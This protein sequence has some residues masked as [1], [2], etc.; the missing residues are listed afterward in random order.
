MADL[1]NLQR[2]TNKWLPNISPRPKLQ[3]IYVHIG[4]AIDSCRQYV[5]SYLHT[6]RPIACLT[7]RTL[8]AV[9]VRYLLLCFP[10]ALS[11][12]QATSNNQHIAKRLLADAITL[13]YKEQRYDD[14]IALLQQARSLDSHN[15]TYRY[16]MAAICYRQKKYADVI[17]LMKSTLRSSK[18]N[19]EYYRLLGNAYDLGG[20]STRAEK[21][22]KRGIKRFK[23]AGSLYAEMGGMA[24]RR[25]NNDAAAD[26]W[27]RGI[28]KAPNFATNY[29]WAATL[30]CHSSEKL[31]GLLYAELFM[32]LEPNGERNETI[33]RLLYDTYAN[34]LQAPTDSTPATVSFSEKAQIYLLLNETETDT[35]LPFQVLYNLEAQ[36][37]MPL[38]LRDKNLQTLYVFRKNWLARW[39]TEQ[40]REYQPNLVFD[41]QQTIETAQHTEAYN[42][43][44]LRKGNPIE[45]N[46]WL[47]Q[48]PYTFK[49][50]IDW[51]NQNPLQLGPSLQFYRRQ[52]LSKQ[53][54]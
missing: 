50:F 54:P 2:L 22:Y 36:W 53:T 30:Y 1:F 21:I 3:P 35:V 51:F 16:E 12:Q 44:L 46:E 31:W 15:P 39:Q 28:E 43:W 5:D 20:N 42:Y 19:A 23:K 52:Y 11:A 6:F 37:A 34:A 18:A 45:F 9:V 48:H 14:A 26:W 49:E 38:P 7:T 13:V 4:Y 32:N 17:R 47:R 27:E 24:Y 33:S 41:R 25:G 8:T 10:A 29:Y 40:H